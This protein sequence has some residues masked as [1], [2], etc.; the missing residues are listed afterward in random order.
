MVRSTAVNEFI[1]VDIHIS[2]AIII[3]SFNV[4]NFPEVKWNLSP[5]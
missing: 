1:L 2:K 3:T 5:I 4:M